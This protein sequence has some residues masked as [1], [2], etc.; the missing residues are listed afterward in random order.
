MKRNDDIKKITETNREAWN[1]ATLVHQKARKDDL[2]IKFSRPGYSTLDKT[3]TEILKEIGIEGKTVAQ[4][5]C[6]NGRETL[7]LVNLGAK[8][9]VG[10]DL[11]DKAIEEALKLKEISGLNCRFVRTDVY[12]IDP[13]YFGLFDIVYISIGALS[14]LPDLDLFFEIASNML[15]SG[16]ALF[17][18]EMHPVTNMVSREDEPE[19]NPQMPYNN[20]YSYFRKEPWVATTGFDYVG[21]TKYDSKPSYSYSYPL[22]DIING[23]IKSGITIKRFNEY[24]HDI[25]AIFEDLEKDG[26]LPL[27]YILLGEKI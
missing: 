27:S 3:E 17:I 24:P 13:K 15:K 9:A 20:C 10:F 5:C 26:I 19:Y 21:G 2:L 6:N 16:G 12:D 22:A 11:S 23:I 1:K 4:L 7:S 18:Y 8:S 25:S 14:W